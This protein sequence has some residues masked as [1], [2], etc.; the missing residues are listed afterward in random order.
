MKSNINITDEMK[1]RSIL[2]Y[3]TPSRLYSV[4]SKACHGE[5]IT[6]A[7]IGGSITQGCLALYKKES[8]AEIVHNWFKEKFPG[9]VINYINAGIGA[10]DSYIGVHRVERD[11]LRCNPD[12]VITEFSV[13]DSDTELNSVTYDSLVKRIL[14]SEKHPAVILLF[15][16]MESGWNMQSVHS[17]TGFNYNLPMISYADAIFSEI[18]SGNLKWSDIS[19]DDIHPNSFGHSIIAE[20]ICSYLDKVYDQYFNSNFENDDMNDIFDEDIYSSAYIADNRTLLALS[21]EKFEKSKVSYQFPYGW[22][23]FD[24][25]YIQFNLFAANIGIIYYKCTNGNYGKFEIIV[26]GKSCSILDGDFSG[27]WGNYA[28][29]KQIFTSKFQAEHIVEIKPYKDTTGKEF[30]ILGFCIS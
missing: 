8:Y 28:E 21:S 27:G 25:G 4:I 14:N 5:A 2:N 9:T 18:N 11:V 7:V 20:L 23:T 24:S 1:E 15:T 6:F 3:G 29:S 19:P 22:K 16:L 12:I 17:K 10:T 13:N 30:C 26:D